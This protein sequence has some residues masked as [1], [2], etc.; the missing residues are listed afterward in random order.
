LP[1]DEIAKVMM[2]GR[3][4]GNRQKWFAM[5]FTGTDAATL[6]TEY[7]ELDAWEWVNPKQLPELIVPFMRSLYLEVLPSSAR[8]GQG[9]LDED[10]PRLDVR[11]SGDAR[12]ARGP[13]PW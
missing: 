3:Y 11:V 2:G 9:M 12:L 6:P 10:L 4:R 13:L 8:F 7:A 1:P 5:R